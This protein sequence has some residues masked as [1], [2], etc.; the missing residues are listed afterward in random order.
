[1]GFNYIVKVTNTEDI[2]KK[3]GLF[4]LILLFF[5]ITFSKTISAKL[6]IIPPED[7]V[8]Q[9]TLIVVGTI[10]K[11]EYSQ[12]HR[13]VGISV[14]TVVKG[15]TEQKEINLKLDEPPMYGWLGFD[16]PD[17]GTKILVLL[18][19]NDQFTLTGETNAV[20]ILEDHNV[21][22]Y[23]GTTMGQWTTEQYE[24]T[25]KAFLE[26]SIM[27]SPT[28]KDQL[29]NKGETTIFGVKSHHLEYKMVMLINLAIIVGIVLITILLLYR[30]SKHKKQR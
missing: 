27:S 26:K 3:S 18:R 20:A 11:K 19:Q 2:M 7:M 10:T 25:Y 5:L 24:K 6:T 14:Q 1:M 22:L 12:K 29:I 16:F 8:E 23:R 9:S 30:I 4:M 15:T 17:T 28:S 21:K 13:E